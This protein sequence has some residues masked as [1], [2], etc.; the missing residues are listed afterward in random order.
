MT[1]NYLPGTQIQ[2]VREVPRGKFKHALFD[3]D[4][5]VSLL[6]E[7][8]Q[9]VMKPV[10]IECIC[11][12]H[13]CTP[14]IEHEVMEFIH[15]T[16]GINTILQMEGLVDMVRKKGFVPED[17][18]L[19]AHG[20]KKIYNDRLMVRVSERIQQMAEGKLSPEE[21]TVRG[22][23]AFV[24]A[25]HERGLYMCIFS[26][27]DHEDVEHEAGL[28]GV[29]SYFTEVYGARKTYAES[30]KEK[31]LRK[32]IEDHHLHGSEVLI[33]GDG[34][35]EIKVA[36]QE[37]CVSIG[38]CSNELEGCG[39]DEVKRQRLADAGAD[40]LIPDFGE[41]DALIAYLFP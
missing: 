31:V 27:T 7:G 3:F 15:E 26:G 40:I 9:Q 21:T 38:V 30:N 11:G 23:V 18:M 14:E 17:K 29:R 20:Y 22:S 2:V 16:T 10:M 28:V 1:I 37:G 4:G 19:D 8:W 36:K 32:A 34:P 5:T 33:V 13:L 24:K 25:M 41:R 6:R 35:V 12:E 39:W